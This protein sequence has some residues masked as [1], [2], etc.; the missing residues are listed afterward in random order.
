M[1]EIKSGIVFLLFLALILPEDSL[2]VIS[3][4]PSLANFGLIFN[5]YYIDE[6]KDV[7]Y[8]NVT[9]LTNAKKYVSI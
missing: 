2:S 6:D 5:A 3:W 7:C 8:K 1:A 4:L 9:N